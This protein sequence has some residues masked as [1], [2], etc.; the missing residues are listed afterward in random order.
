M[1]VG[2]VA[3]HREV[4]AVELQEKAVPDDGFVFDAQRLA[5]RLEVGGFVRIM[6][7]AQR[8][9]DDAR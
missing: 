4:R 9:G 2:D 8:C 5:E 3:F 1:L 7:V 6:V